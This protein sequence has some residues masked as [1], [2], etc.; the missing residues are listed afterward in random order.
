[1]AEPRT[2]IPGQ[3]DPSFFVSY[4]DA[5]EQRISTPADLARALQKAASNL[6]SRMLHAMQLGLFSRANANCGNPTISLDLVGTQDR[7]PALAEI[8]QNYGELL[9][10]FSQG[11]QDDRRGD[12]RM[13]WPVLCIDEANKLMAWAEDDRNEQRELDALLNF[14]IRVRARLPTPVCEACQK[15]NLHFVGQHNTSY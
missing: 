1:M 3:A 11:R 10:K 4:I 7:T 15:F 9:A 5:R 12:A 14:F 8:I 13:P 6:K 2:S